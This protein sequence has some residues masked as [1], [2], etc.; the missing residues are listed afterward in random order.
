MIIYYLCNICWLTNSYLTKNI[1]CLMFDNIQLSVPNL[2]KNIDIT[3]YV[4]RRHIMGG[5]NRTLI[6]AETHL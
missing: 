1:A 2:Q 4:V 5:A 3:T 6:S